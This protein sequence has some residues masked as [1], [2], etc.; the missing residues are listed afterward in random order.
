ITRNYAASVQKG[1][2]TQAEMDKR[3]ALIRPTL[4]FS[5]FAEAD[6]VVEAVFESLEIKKEVFRSLDRFAKPDAILATNTSTLD[7][8]AIASATHRPQQVIGHHFFSPANIMKL[9][10][11]VRGTK[12]SC[13]VIAA[14]MAL[15]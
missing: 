4:N 5:D 14:S 2:M 6:I 12:T 3:M 11:I 9:L 1:K 15:S 7:I 10:E 13:P 8:D